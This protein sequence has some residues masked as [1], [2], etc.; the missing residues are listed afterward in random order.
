MIGRLWRNTKAISSI[1]SVP[2]GQLWRV[3]A[4]FAL[5]NSMTVNKGSMPKRNLVEKIRISQL[6][7]SYCRKTRIHKLKY[8]KYQDFSV[9]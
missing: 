5:D 7:N 8:S 9:N 2:I 6:T 4:T 3:I 1:Y